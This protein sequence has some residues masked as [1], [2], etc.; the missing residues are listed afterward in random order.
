MTEMNPI[1]VQSI[2]L[3]PQ[4][5]YFGKRFIPLTPQ[6]VQV[7][8]TWEQFLDNILGPEFEVEEME[9]LE[10]ALKKFKGISE[11]K[12]ENPYFWESWAP[13]WAEYSRRNLNR[14]LQLL[15]RLDRLETFR[16]IISLGAGSCCQEVFLAQY[17]CPESRVFGLD[18]SHHM[19]KHGILLA[20]QRGI[21]NIYFTVGKVE[22]LPLADRT[23][24]LIISINLLNLI[25]DVPGV[26]REI[27]RILSGSPLNRYFF[28]FPLDPRDRLQS[29]AEIWKIM[30]TEAGLESPKLFCL[31]GKNYKDKSLRLLVLTN[32]ETFDNN[33]GR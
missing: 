22:H 5:T 26:L 11:Q 2:K 30:I 33:S 21:N 23:S 13:N 20:R 12:L 31:S 17:C 10:R 15:N 24:D 29:R 19:I 27:N 14:G 6:Q 9:A 1:L 8:K 7:E 16:R 28:L 3:T 25:P 32:L 4:G 18:F